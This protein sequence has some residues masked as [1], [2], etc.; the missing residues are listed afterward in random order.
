MQRI[1]E[2]EAKLKSYSDFTWNL[3]NPNISQELLPMYL[4]TKLLNELIELRNALQGGK[5]SEIID[6]A[7]D[8][9]WYFANEHRR[10]N[11]I[12]SEVECYLDDIEDEISVFLPLDK[13]ISAANRLNQYYVKNIFHGKPLPDDQ[14]YD[15]WM[16]WDYFNETINLVD[17]TLEEVIDHNINKLTDRHGAK[18]NKEFYSS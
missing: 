2:M 10:Q 17:I 1:M 4:T 12:L 14:I 8:C 13:A 18:Y 16:A 5:R 6:E 9:V 7:G 15:L 11:H 3:L